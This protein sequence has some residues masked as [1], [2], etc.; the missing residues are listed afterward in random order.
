[1]RL[2][3]EADLWVEQEARRT[4]H[5][6]S[7]I[8]ASLVEEATRI[9]RFPGIAF[10]GPDDD[11]RAWL[12]GAGFDVWELIEAFQGMGP[13]RFREEGDI[14]ERELE[15]ALTYYAAYPE[16]IIQAIA[17]NDITG[18]EL[19]ALYPDLFSKA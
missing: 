13:V 15:L 6:K 19:E 11:R 14:P 7:A 18:E 9:R 1:M 4:G 5:P 3:M 16:E 8:V 10:R 2:S 17:A 12:P